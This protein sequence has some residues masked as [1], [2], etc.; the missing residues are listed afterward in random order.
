M[1]AVLIFIASLVT[2]VYPIIVYFG[3]QRLSP[4]FFALVLLALAVVKFVVAKGKKDMLQLLILLLAVI[5]SVALAISNSEILL[6]LYP[7]VISLGV[8]LIFALSLSQAETVIERMARLAGEE[9]TPR[10]KFYTRRLTIVWV[11][12]LIA[13]ASVAFYLALFGSMGQWAFYCGFL[14]YVIFGGVFIV[15]LLY[16]RFYIAKH[17]RL[18]DKP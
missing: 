5:F 10:A 15:E 1:K 3:I 2:L 16:R 12:L 13:N 4:A 9:I 14:A 6:R 17:Q 7:V 8:A 18:A 11:A